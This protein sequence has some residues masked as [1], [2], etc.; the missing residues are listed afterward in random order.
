MGK[1]TLPSGG[2]TALPLTLL[3][4]AIPMLTRNDL[5]ALTER[6]IDHLDTIDPDPEAEEIPVEDAQITYDLPPEEDGTDPD[7]EQTR[8]E[9]DWYPHASDGPG[10]PLADAG[11]AG[12]YEDDEDDD[13]SGQCDEDGINTGSGNFFEHGRPIPGAGCPI[14]DPGCDYRNS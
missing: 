8:D 2:A 7:F 10:C 13:P 14:S 9:D 1:H 5:E 3:A 6:L 11:G 12:E 4:Q